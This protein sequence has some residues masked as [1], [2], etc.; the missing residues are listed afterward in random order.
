MMVER[1]GPPPARRAVQFR[2]AAVTPASVP[3]R[4]R[5]ATPLIIVA[6]IITIRKFIILTEERYI[7]LVVTKAQKISGSPIL[8]SLDEAREIL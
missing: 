5:L 7:Y 6:D 4:P 1:P 2:P 3:P 8:Q